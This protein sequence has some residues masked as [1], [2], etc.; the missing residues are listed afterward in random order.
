MFCEIVAGERAAHV[1]YDEPDVMAFLDR[2]PV[3]HGH[4]LVVPRLH[5]DT[6]LDL[7]QALLGA[8]FAA[9]QAIT[10]A[11]IAGTDSHGAFVALNNTVSQSVPHL[12]VHVVPRRFKD[13]L[14][15]FFWPR[16]PYGSDEEATA[17]AGR[18][19]AAL[20][21]GWEPASS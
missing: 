17:V 5:V 14:K 13:G 15:G 4:T 9:V 7:D 12:H 18:I 8:L 2:R 21:S 3:F 20:A 1:V 10:G 11:V 6:L 16:H 19:R